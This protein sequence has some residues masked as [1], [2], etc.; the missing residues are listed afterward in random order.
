MTSKLTLY[1]WNIAGIKDKLQDPN[2]LQFI[3]KFDIVWILE[4]K[5]YFNLNVPGFTVYE[6]ISRE[7]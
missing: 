6:N 4:A 5:K 3:L 2:I 7:G 1:S